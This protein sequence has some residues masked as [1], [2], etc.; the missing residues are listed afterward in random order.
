MDVDRDGG[1]G[2][3]SGR[4]TAGSAEDAKG[5]LEGGGAGGVGEA[6]V[7]AGDGV[8]EEVSTRAV[9]NALKVRLIC[10]L[11]VDVSSPN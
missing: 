7:G 2:G 6:G 10:P 5:R 8:V 11:L 9:M 4:G 1:V 3:A